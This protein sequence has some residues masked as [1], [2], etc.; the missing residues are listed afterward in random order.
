MKNAIK[1]VMIY[2]PA[3][4]TRQGPSASDPSPVHNRPPLAQTFVAPSGQAFT[5]VVN[6]L[7]SKGCDGATGADRDQGDL[8]G[9]FN[10]T[11]VAQARATRSFVASLLPGV[12]LPNVL[13]VGDFNAYAKEDPIVEMT[14]NGYVDEIGRFN[15]FG[16]SY[17]FDGAA[18]RLDQAIT[19]ASLSPKVAR[20]IEWHIN[21][22]EPAV[23]DYNLERTAS[24]GIRRAEEMEQVSLTLSELGIAPLR[25]R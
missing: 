5:L 6:H 10:A 8:Q 7:K 23:I 15:A 22:D 20:A 18:G 3:R 25:S 13:L 4:L 21:A 16:Y 2:K 12:P 17:V 24:H 1:V 14:G 19:T 11:R 9:C